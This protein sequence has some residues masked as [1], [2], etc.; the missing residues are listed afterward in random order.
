MGNAVTGV[1]RMSTP[2]LAESHMSGSW[3]TSNTTLM[4][5]WLRSQSKLNNVKQF[6][7]T[8]L[9]TVKTGKRC[10]PSKITVPEMKK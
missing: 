7:R 5:L 1:M 3:T 9:M 4:A 6:G 10:S 2:D 8:P